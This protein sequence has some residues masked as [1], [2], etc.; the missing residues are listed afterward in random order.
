MNPC[1]F[2]VDAVVGG[3]GVYGYTVLLISPLYCLLVFTYY[4]LS[5][6]LVSLMYTLGQ[7]LQGTW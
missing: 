3:V 4:D 2:P 7:S 1:S 5:V 6:L